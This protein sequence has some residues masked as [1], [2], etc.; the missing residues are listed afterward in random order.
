M[1]I[2]QRKFLISAS[3]L[4]CVS[5]RFVVSVINVSASHETDV[6]CNHLDA[7]TFQN[8]FLNFPVK[9]LSFKWPVKVIGLYLIIFKRLLCS[10]DIEM[11]PG[12]T[13]YF[14]KLSQKFLKAPKNTKFFHINCQSIAQKKEQIKLILNEL[15]DNTICGLSE[16]WLKESTDQKLWELNKEHFKTFRFDRRLGNK[17]KGGGVILIIPKTLNPKSR[18]DLNCMNKNQLESLWFE[19]NLNNDPTNKMRQLIIISYNP[20]KSL[21]DPFLEELS[22]S[23][24]TAIAENKPITLMGDFNINFLTIKNVNA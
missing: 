9:R 14:E 6:L 11:N 20:S 3:I 7:P 2:I 4:F 19:C 22:T 1:Q 5:I 16:T 10:G 12:P 18:N 21:F 13:V 15:G 24:D 8:I 23:I 17:T